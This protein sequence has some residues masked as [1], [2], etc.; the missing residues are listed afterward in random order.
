MSFPM[1]GRILPLA[2]GTFRALAHRNFRLL[3]IGQL[4]SLS[5]SWMQ[6][7][8]QGWLVLRLTDSAFYLG[9]VGFCNFLPIM[10][11]ALPA[12]VAA[13]RLRPRAALIGIQ[14]FALLNATA[15]ATIT[16]L[17]IVRPWHIVLFA[18]GNGTVAAF[19]IPIRQRFLQDLVGRDDLPN[20]IALNSLAFNGA[21]L[22]GPS[23]AG[24]LVALAGEAACF[25]INAVTYL[26]VL[27]A[28]VAID[29]APRAGGTDRTSFGRQL[30]DGVSYAVRSPRVRTLLSLV[31]VSAAFGMPYQVLL[32]VFARD[33]LGVGSRGLGILMGAAGL[34]AVAGAL[35]LAGRRSHRRSAGVVA[36][37]MTA[38]GAGLVGL[39]LSRSFP[40]SIAC[41]TVVGAATIVQM[42]TSNT[43]LQ[44]SAPPELRGRVISL[45]LLAFAGSAPI[46]SLVAGW[47]A[48]SHGVETT[49][50]V[51]GAVCLAAA[52]AFAT[53]IPAIRR[54]T[55]A[56]EAEERAAR[57][58]HAPPDPGP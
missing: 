15:L 37:A 38:F 49:V 4:V 55:L 39:A 22:I 33:L 10:L 34:G 16:G 31:I 30:A 3:W 50:G 46:G 56:R 41:I 18:L 42:A 14:S 17:G 48:R 29:V 28:L 6:S 9:L 26:A 21:R 53:R 1:P 13:D 57:E 8:A 43:L 32:P 25:G 36:T 35:Y 11:F 20:A 27:A 5:G 2:P 12:G 47:A 19:E 24:F 52:A 7:T 44:L 45:Y 54:A 23:A 51:G 58:A 40:L